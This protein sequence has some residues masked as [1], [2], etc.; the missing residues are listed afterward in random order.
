LDN[1]DSKHNKIDSEL[2]V[3]FSKIFENHLAKINKRVVFVTC[4][5]SEKRNLPNISDALDNSAA[6][7][8]LDP[9]SRNLE[10][11]VTKNNIKHKESLKNNYFTK[12]EYLY[13]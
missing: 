10:D 8:F 3:N 13:K 7:I 1:F 11:W 2:S 6:Q 5:N 9:F 4:Y 12:T